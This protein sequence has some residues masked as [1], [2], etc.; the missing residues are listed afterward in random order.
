LLEAALVKE[1]LCVIEDHL[2]VLEF[3]QVSKDM[4]R[5]L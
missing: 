3:L 1:W 5:L 4:E 2:G